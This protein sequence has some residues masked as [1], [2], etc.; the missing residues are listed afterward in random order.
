MS[1]LY[2]LSAKTIVTLIKNKEIQPFEVMEEL[3]GLSDKLDHK[4]RVW[5]TFDPEIARSNSKSIPKF[6]GVFEHFYNLSIYKNVSTHYINLAYEYEINDFYDF[7]DFPKEQHNKYKWFT[8]N[9]LLED[10]KV[11]KYVKEYFRKRI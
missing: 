1:E 6:I 3:I 10:K 9:E 8:L 7:K 2:K 5:E 4:L 11:H